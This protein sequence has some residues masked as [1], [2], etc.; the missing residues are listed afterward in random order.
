MTPYL[1]KCMDNHRHQDKSPWMETD[2]FFSSAP[3][4]LPSSVSGCDFLK[5]LSKA[6]KH[7]PTSGSIRMPLW[8]S[9][10]QFS[11]ITRDESAK[12][13][14]S[15][16]GEE[17][18]LNYIYFYNQYLGKRHFQVHPGIY[19]TDLPWC[20]GCLPPWPSSNPSQDTCMMLSPCF[21]YINLGP[22]LKS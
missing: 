7:L 4:C 2:F 21:L 11:A 9:F 12:A 20:H 22:T 1:E 3:P 6:I 5:A 14:M 8:F 16:A 10:E 15:G 17:Q 19:S 18:M 13:S